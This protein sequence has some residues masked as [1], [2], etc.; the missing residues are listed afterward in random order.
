MIEHAAMARQNF[1]SGMTCAQAV[2]CA[3]GD[4]TG[5]DRD[6]AMRVSASFGGGLGA[7]REVCGAVS[8]A[9]MVL[10]LVEGWTEPGD[11]PAKKAHYARVQEFARRFRDAE[12]SILCREL[13]TGAGVVPRTDPSERSESY[14]QKRP[15]PEL[16]AEAARLLDELLAEGRA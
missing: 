13:L 1:L 6:T 4:I 11:F 12:G 10:G 15:C 3:F 5:L 7:L 9:L 8:G 14:Y 2:L 16:V